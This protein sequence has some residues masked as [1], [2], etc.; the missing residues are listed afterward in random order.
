[1]Q[2]SQSVEAMITALRV[3]KSAIEREPPNPA[4]IEVLRRVAPL[5]GDLPMTWPAL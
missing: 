2:Q 5:Q 4:D 1:M 3:L